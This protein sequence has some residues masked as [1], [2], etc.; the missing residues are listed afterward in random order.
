MVFLFPYILS[1]FKFNF[2]RAAE[3][4]F[5]SITL[6]TFLFFGLISALVSKQPQLSFIGNHSRLNGYMFYA[7]LSLLVLSI[8]SNFRKN[9]IDTF[10]KI[11][12]VSGIFLILYSSIQYFNLDFVQ[13]NLSFNRVV[14]TLGNPDFNSA[15]LGIIGIIGFYFF[16]AE[17]RFKKLPYLCVSLLSL[18]LAISTNA[19]QGPFIYIL[20][21]SILLALGKPQKRFKLI[22]ISIMSSV[23]ILLVTFGML[24]F[25]PFASWIYK[26]SIT[27][28]GD[29]WRA[30]WRMFVDN[31]F[32]GVGF[33]RYGDYFRQYRDA[34]QVTRRGSELTADQPHNV[35]LDILST[36]GLFTFVPYILFILFV[37][38]LGIKNIYATSNKEVRF[39]STALFAIFIAYL[40]QSFISI[41]QIALALIGWSVAGLIILK[42]LSDDFANKQKDLKLNI[43]NFF[44]P[45]VAMSISLMVLVPMWR[46]DISSRFINGLA[47]NLDNYSNKQFVR[48]ETDKL[49]K[50][51]SIDSYY[52]QVAG[53]SY[54]RLKEF[55]LAVLLFEKS[56]KNN[57]RDSISAAYLSS[58]Y[59]QTN[60]CEKSLKYSYIAVQLDPF[61][62]TNL[63]DRMRCL[64]KIGKKSEALELR[65]RILEID[66]QNEFAKASREL[67]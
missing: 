60:D 30:G 6:L 9:K 38:Y 23:I 40:T 65:N 46:S 15:Y 44:G 50:I 62:Q 61:N 18:T 14:G 42:S 35:F 10:L 13:W 29:Y 67:L 22:L 7:T 36:G 47:N 64:V 2:L 4:R 28:R 21:I 32:F 48:S 56:V 17:V 27:F 16:L 43:A 3:L 5:V 34:T 39:Q 49:S 59:M 55:D 20:G 45:L 41:D 31:P 58:I 26:P 19:K 8:I 52:L 51:N 25:G 11:I 54:L 24:N 63:L 1:Q 53:I 12:L 37:V 66:S 33:G 57:S